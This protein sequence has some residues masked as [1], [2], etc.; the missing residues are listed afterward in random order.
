MKKL[1]IGLLAIGSLT[2]FGNPDDL[3][4]K[5]VG[6]YTCERFEKDLRSNTEDNSIEKIIVSIHNKNI[7]RLNSSQ[8]YNFDYGLGFEILNS[9]MITDGK[10]DCFK[11]E[12]DFSI[13]LV[14]AR[15]R[16]VTS[17]WKGTIQETD[18][19][20]VSTEHKL[21][22]GGVIERVCIRN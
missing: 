21:V 12:I 19:G 8:G 22:R 15:T 11:S 3:C 10:A 17:S 6:S 1:L 16:E 13:K 2:A 7:F 20:F 5:L 14:R 18:T 9:F 4:S